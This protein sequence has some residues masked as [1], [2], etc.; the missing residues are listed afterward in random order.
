MS[1]IKKTSMEEQIKEAPITDN[2]PSLT[3][4]TVGHFTFMNHLHFLEEPGTFLTWGSVHELLDR[5]KI[6]SE[7]NLAGINE[8]GIPFN[9]VDKGN[10]A[11]HIALGI[12][13]ERSDELSA[14][15]TKFMK[16]QVETKSGGFIVEHLKFIASISNSNEEALWCSFLH[17]MWMNVHGFVKPI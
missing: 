3:E 7:H 10:E 12:S 9:I 15:L 16:D 8:P 14:I 5:L 13:E 11:M 17:G 1:K 4:G 2:N 6:R